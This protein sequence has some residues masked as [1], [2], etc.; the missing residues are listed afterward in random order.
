MRLFVLLVMISFFLLPG[1][2]FSQSFDEEENLERYEFSFGLGTGTAFETDIFKT[3]AA[4]V[5]ASP[6]PLINLSMHYTMDENLSFGFLLEGYAQT[7]NNIPVIIKGETK[8]EKFD[9]ACDNI[10]LDVRWTFSRSKFE[11]YGFIAINLVTGSLQNDD[12][13]NLTMTGMSFG[14]G[15]GAKL[16]FSKHWAASVEAVGFFG[17]AKWK[18]KIFTNSSGTSFNPGHAGATIG[19]VYRWGGM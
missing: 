4:K 9:L 10:G 15:L 19:V 7:I 14:G 17:T 5:K 2:V 18:Q 8:L 12:L 6:E 1:K 16:N 3:D 11:P 13:G